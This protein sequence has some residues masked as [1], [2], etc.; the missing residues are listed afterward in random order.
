[1]TDPSEDSEYEGSIRTPVYAPF[2]RSHNSCNLLLD[3]A[4]RRSLLVRLTGRELDINY[5]ALVRD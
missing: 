5:G 1:M 3:K 4:E 2:L